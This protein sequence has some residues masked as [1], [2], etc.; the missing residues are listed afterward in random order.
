MDGSLLTDPGSDARVLVFIGQAYPP[1]PL[2][3][4]DT[5][6]W[7]L[8]QEVNL[9]VSGSMIEKGYT[10]VDAPNSVP[11]Q[12]AD[13]AVAVAATYTDLFGSP[14]NAY[15]L[16]AVWGGGMIATV[17][18]DEPASYDKQN[19]SVA[20]MVLNPFQLGALAN[21]SAASAPSASLSPS[22]D[23]LLYASGSGNR[24]TDEFTTTGRVQV[25]WQTSGESPDGSIGPDV[26]FNVEPVGNGSY[27]ND[28]DI[29][30]EESDCS[31]AYL[32]P[33]TYY[34]KVIGTD[35]TDWTVTVT[36][37]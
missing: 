36:A 7:G 28:F 26:S 1:S 10:V 5:E 33:G 22:S 4:S 29:A 6:N 8:Q 24:N 18:V 2:S 30:D 34:V 20:Q 35:S 13:S 15:Y 25:C 16:I 14:T 19:P 12:G 11:L 23:A 27:G 31:Y 3:P 9:A 37:A 17:R 21:E 32:D